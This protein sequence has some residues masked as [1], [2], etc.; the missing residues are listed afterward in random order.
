[1]VYSPA[2][3]Q[4]SIDSLCGACRRFIYVYKFNWLNWKKQYRLTY[5]EDGKQKGTTAQSLT[6]AM[7]RASLIEKKLLA[8]CGNRSFLTVAEMIDKYLNPDEEDTSR[9]EW[10]QRFLSTNE[11]GQK[12]HLCINQDKLDH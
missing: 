6:H 3:S 7:E 11:T 5:F 9:G 8:K 2:F 1:M 12:I 4:L 10:G